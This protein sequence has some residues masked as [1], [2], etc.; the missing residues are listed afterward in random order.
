MLVPVA[1][2]RTT[3]ASIISTVRTDQLLP[4]DTDIVNNTA[5]VQMCGHR[6]LHISLSSLHCMLAEHAD[7]CAGRVAV[8]EQAIAWD[9]Y[10]LEPLFFLPVSCVVASQ[11][12]LL[13]VFC[14]SLD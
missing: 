5:H 11:C 4:M 13:L 10:Y 9:L 1:L 6:I 12:S 2:H 8:V 3:E 7:E 14:G